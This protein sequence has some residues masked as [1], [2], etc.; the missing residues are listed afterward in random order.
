MS[1]RSFV[2]LSA[3]LFLLPR[4]LT[5]APVGDIASLDWLTGCWASDDGGELSEEC[6]LHPAGGMMLG[7]NRTVS[8]NGSAFEFLRIGS[9]PEGIA[10]YASPSGR[11]AVPFLL[12]DSGDDLAVFA[13]PEHDFPQRITYRRE[14]D[15][16][17]AR[18]EA[19]DGQEWN[20]FE[21]VWR[22]STLERKLEA[23]PPM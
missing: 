6:W 21:L 14:G 16:L 7:F 23:P 15:R 12:V 22:R 19:L 8:E 18:V 17:S 1:P 9:H 11:T 3:A 10:F 13:N 4:V 20:G 2:V 5:A